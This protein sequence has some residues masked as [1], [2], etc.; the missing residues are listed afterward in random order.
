M[1]TTI[2]VRDHALG[3]LGLIPV[4]QAAQDQDR[5]E[6]ESYYTRIYADLLSSGL[7]T[8]ISAGPL[9]DEVAPHVAALMAWQGTDTYGVSPA[10]YQSIAAKASVARREIRRLVRPR[11]EGLTDQTDF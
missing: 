2:E 10:R 8:W 11:Y 5:V 9:P 6:V 3:L 4:G 7:A 1:A